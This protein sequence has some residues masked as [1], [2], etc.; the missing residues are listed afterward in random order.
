MF[1]YFAWCRGDSRN[2]QVGTKYRETAFGSCLL[3]GVGNLAYFSYKKISCGQYWAE[4]K[5]GGATAS[6]RNPALSDERASFSPE[7]KKS[8][9]STERRGRG[10]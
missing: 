6:N 1:S 2:S 4:D 9:L 8:I 5:D 3:R 10:G 7:E